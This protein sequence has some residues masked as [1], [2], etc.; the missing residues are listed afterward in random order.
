[1]SARDAVVA[2]SHRMQNMQIKLKLF[3]VT[4]V[5]TVPITDLFAEVTAQS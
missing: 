1:M 5:N 4:C 2:I 3:F